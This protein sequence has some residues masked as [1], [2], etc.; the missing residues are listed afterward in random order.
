MA[1]VLLAAFQYRWR[2]LYGIAS[3]ESYV[4][5]PGPGSGTI[6]Y[7]NRSGVPMGGTKDH[8]LYQTY[9]YGDFSYAFAVP[10]AGAYIVQIELIEPWWNALAL[11]CSMGA[12]GLA[13]LVSTISTS[14]R[15]P[16]EN[17]RRLPDRDRHR[18]R[19]HPRS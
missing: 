1:D 16:A 17:S 18:E 13:R 12:R 11:G 4:A 6:T 14:M 10:G 19:R 2:S 15:A 9:G 5:D 3:G 8:V 7:S